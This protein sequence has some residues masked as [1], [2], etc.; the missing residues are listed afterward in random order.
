M[1]TD[2]NGYFNSSFF[3]GNRQK[4]AALC[5]NNGPIVV[6]ANGLLQRSGDTTFPFTQDSNFWY[7][8]GLEEPDLVL[9]IDEGDEYLIVPK[10]DAVV[11]MFDG[12]LTASV[13]RTTSGIAHVYDEREG[14][15]KLTKRLKTVKRAATPLAPPAYIER[16]GF[17]TNPA[18]A[19]LV[20]KLKRPNGNLKIIDIREQLMTMRLIK[21]PQEI[22]AIQRAIDIT[23]R[24]IEQIVKGLGGYTTEAEVDA[25]L[26]Y[27][28]SRRGGDGHAFTPIVASG[29]HTGQIH[30]TANKD[31]LK[32]PFL[33][34]DV[35]AEVNHYA[36][37]ITRT[38]A[39][40]NP[41]RRARDVFE[42]VAAVQDYALG[43]LKPGADLR[44]NENK[45]EAH[46]G[47]KLKQLGLIKRQT[48]KSIR[49]YYP[50]ATSHYVGLDVHD[51]GGYDRPLEQDMIVT[52]EPGIYIDEEGFGV[53]IEDDVLITKSGC[54]V[55]SKGLPRVL[56]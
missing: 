33:L 7:L 37:D 22:K 36:A 42:A 50:H 53:R 44:D 46:M 9:V 13:V 34:L 16:H 10:K 17:Y 54:A 5:A 19:S 35:G 14:W 31:L 2:G 52:V 3:A 43:L 1:K 26:T 11:A 18:R 25:A 32:G 48:K 41:S 30:Y 8:T 55:L 45:V 21:Q 28:F 49:T 51:V 20:D 47:Q 23:A 40:G 56:K 39:L 15:E 38:I 29:T 27:E 24:S 12:Q 4:L 6:T